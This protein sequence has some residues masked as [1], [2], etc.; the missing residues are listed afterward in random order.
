MALQ[1]YP[2]LG[3]SGQLGLSHLLVDQVLDLWLL[4]EGDI[5][6]GEAVLVCKAI[7]EE[8]SQLRTVRQQH[9]SCHRNKSFKGRFGGHF[10]VSNNK[11][12]FPW[13]ISKT[14]EV[15]FVPHICPP[16]K[17]LEDTSLGKLVSP[18]ENKHI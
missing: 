2:E 11:I 3:R 10:I 12:P 17:R 9:F 13:L 6:L 14:L 15:S 16:R 7:P 5:T 4:W 8:S 1:T 18:R